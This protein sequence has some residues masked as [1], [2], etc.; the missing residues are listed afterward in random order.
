MS[1]MKKVSVPKLGITAHFTHRDAMR[2]RGTS[3]RFAHAQ[4]AP[5]PTTLPVDSTGNAT[6]LCPMDGNDTLGDCG[7]A[8]VDHSDRILMWRQGKG[9]QLNTSL[10]ALE[11]QYEQVSG[12]DNG[13]DEDLV[14]N[15]IWKVGIAGNPLAVIVDALDIDVTNVALAQFAL[16]QF[17]TIQMAWSVPDLFVQTFADGSV[18]SSA[19]TPNPAN[20]H[21]VPLADVTASGFYGMY[22]WGSRCLVGP[23]FVASVEPQC[24]VAFSPRQFD[25]STGLDSK[26]RHIV[27]QAAK[28]VACGGRPIPLAVINA[29]PPLGTP[30]VPAP[31][32]PV[33]PPAVN[34]LFM[35]SFVRPVA[36]GGKI[37]FTTPVAVPAGRYPFGPRISGVPVQ[38]KGKNPI[39]ELP[40]TETN[41]S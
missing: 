21:Y 4:E 35:L 25:P 33:P 14:V 10:A 20:G 24:F 23:A 17:Y 1:Q 13:L 15:H 7:E 32:P 26:G 19:M 6:V 41:D 39:V 12:G 18:W 16:D 38:G 28:W 27:Q 29:F 8:M 9:V 36:A 22:T 2:K 37:A 5:P 31:V 30:P 11:A 34:P 3:R 40:P